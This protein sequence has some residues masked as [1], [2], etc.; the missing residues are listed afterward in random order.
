VGDIIAQSLQHWWAVDWHRDI[1][2]RW[3]ASGVRFADSPSAT[4]APSGALSGMTVVISGAIPGYTRG[5]ADDAVRAAGGK[6]S[7][8]VS[9]KTSAVVAGEGSGS[10]RS[11]AE[12]LGVEVIE[13]ID[14]E[15]F[16]AQGTGSQAL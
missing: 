13:A 11:S 7:S 5:G 6:S 3:R 12:A 8:S 2:S 1:V 14:F 4:A 9:K 15:R 10:K 16:L